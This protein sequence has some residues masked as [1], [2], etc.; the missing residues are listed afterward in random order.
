MTTG[1]CLVS[2]NMIMKDWGDKLIQIKHK[3]LTIEEV[4]NEIDLGLKLSKL[5]GIH[6]NDVVGGHLFNMLRTNT[7]RYTVRMEQPLS[8]FFI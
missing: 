4:E 5:V 2:L 1:S 3:P 6:L 8:H 7:I